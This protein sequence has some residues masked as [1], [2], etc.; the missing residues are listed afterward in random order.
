ME[1]EVCSVPS[2]SWAAL[3]AEPADAPSLTALARVEAGALSGAELVDAIVCSEKAASLILGVQ[4]RLMAALTVPFV[5]SDPMPLARKLARRSG[6]LGGDDE[7]GNVQAMVPEAAAGLAA[8]EVAA[9]LRI[10]PVTAGVRVRESVLLTE[11][12]APARQAAEDGVLDR[13]KLRAIVEQA[14]VLPTEVVGPVLGQILAE[15]ADRCTS[16]I[17]EITAQA[18][19]AADPQGAADRHER[20]A[21]RRDVTVSPGTDAMATLKAFLPADGAVKIFQV[22]DLLATGTTGVVGD[23]RGIGARRVDALVDI[24]D[25][26]LAGGIVDLTGYLGRPLP[27][28]GSPTPRARRECAS[29]PTTDH[30]ADD[31]GHS[32]A[33]TGDGASGVDT[34]GSDPVLPVAPE[35]PDPAG[36]PEIPSD[37]TTTPADS[38]DSGQQAGSTS[39]PSRVLSRQ[40]RRPHLTV[41]M[42]LDTLA[43]LNDLPAVLAGFGSIP[44]DLARTIARSAGT[45]T[46]AVTDPATGTVVD[47]GELTYRPRQAVRDQIAVLTDTCQFPSC[48]QPVWRCDIDHREPFNRQDPRRGGPTTVANTEGLCRRHHLLKTHAGWQLSVD[49]SRLVINWTSPTGHTYTR[50]RRQTAPPDAWIRTAGTTIAE[51]LD[52]I[53]QW[54]EN[55]SPPIVAPDEPSAD[56]PTAD[57]GTTPDEPAADGDT[58]DPGPAPS[59]I[60]VRLTDALLRHRLAHPT[61]IEY[62][63]SVGPRGDDPPPF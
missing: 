13:G 55:P 37:S 20:A 15:C 45:I 12:F 27:D 42:S 38:A 21:G 19:I 50:R 11:E 59:L 5:A 7:D 22:S 40:G 60:E 54:R 10:A 23:D 17:R 46:A 26:L 49:T 6:L 61:R 8:A 28:H 63:P 58:T 2:P 56:E 18:V 35:P 24:A 43:G 47:C 41:T 44:A 16:E 9:A 1:D 25:R 62:D 36:I 57:D 32:V 3:A 51:Q 30:R 29:D 4:A 33:A 31:L 48:R 14:Q 34:G 39:N 52:A 53:A